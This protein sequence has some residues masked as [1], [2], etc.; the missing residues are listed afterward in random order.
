MTRL[1]FRWTWAI[2]L[3]TKLAD[4][5]TLGP[6][7]ATVISGDGKHALFPPALP[8]DLLGIAALAAAA[9][10]MPLHASPPFVSI[11]QS[12]IA[13]ASASLSSAGLKP[14]ARTAAII[15]ALSALPLPA[16]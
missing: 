14:R 15:A 12:R 6:G 3:L 10:G 1:T 5:L 13:I 9:A 7:E 8:L 16:A 2:E 4:Q 11:A